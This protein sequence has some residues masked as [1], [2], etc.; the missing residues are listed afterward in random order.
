MAWAEESP[1][2]VRSQVAL[3]Q[4]TE[5]EPVHVM[6]QTALPLQVTLPLG[7]TVVVQVE[8][9]AQLRLHESVQAPEQSVWF[10]QESEQLPALP[11]QVLALNAQLVP[12]LQLQ[13]APEQTGGGGVEDPPQAQRNR[14]QATRS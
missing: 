8:L 7:P 11:P 5:Q 6:W 3:L 9:L 4:L 14:T 1:A 12:E 10:S 2:Q 13:L